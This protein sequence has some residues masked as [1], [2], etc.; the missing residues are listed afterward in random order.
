[1][2]WKMSVA[3]VTVKIMAVVVVSHKGLIIN[4]LIN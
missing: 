3:L 2:H 4:E 1:M